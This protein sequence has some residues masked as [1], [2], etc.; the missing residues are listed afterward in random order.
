MY[1]DGKHK[2]AKVYYSVYTVLHNSSLTVVNNFITNS[3]TLVNPIAFPEESLLMMS[4]E[5][6]DLSHKQYSIC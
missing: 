4:N 6:V 2:T 5:A 3:I 1:H